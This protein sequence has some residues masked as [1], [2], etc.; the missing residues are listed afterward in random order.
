MDQGLLPRGYRPQD[1]D[2]VVVF[3]RW[4]VDAGHDDFHTEIHPPL[5]TVRAHQALSPISIAAGSLVRVP[6]RTNSTVIGRPYLVSQIF[7]LD[8]NGHP[9]GLRSQIEQAL[10]DATVNGDSHTK[11]NVNANIKPGVGA[12]GF[13]MSYIVQPL[14]PRQSPND[15]LLV[16]YHFTVRT[17]VSVSVLNAGDAVEVL[18]QINGLGPDPVLPP[19]G[20]HEATIHVDDFPSNVR[21]KVKDLLA[22]KVED[23]RNDHGNHYANILQSIINNG[24][25]MKWYDPPVPSSPLDQT[26]RVVDFPVDQLPPADSPTTPPGV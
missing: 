17:D 14:S 22:Q 3:G 15:Q 25:R 7:S 10:H 13:K 23:T 21:Q 19:P 20:A 18:I 12:F 16:E 9:R 2:R 4:I 5:I 8:D 11:I 6:D 26:N 24:A 1:G